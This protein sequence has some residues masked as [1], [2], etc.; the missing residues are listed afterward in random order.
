[1]GTVLA[2]PQVHRIRRHGLHTSFWGKTLAQNI[3]RFGYFW[4][5]IIREALQLA[6]SRKQCQVH[7]DLH[8]AAP[9]QLN[10]IRADRPFGTWGIN[11]V[12]LFPTA[13]KQLR[14]LKVA[15]DYYTKWIEAEALATIMASQYRKF[16]WIQVI[17]RFEI[18]EIMI[19]DNR[20]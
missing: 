17:T 15:I 10:V 12:G 6:K 14:F 9:H 5:T 20:T 16:F 4:P 3:I 8:Q 1:M 18:P 13:P 7:A 11:L 19:S 2:P